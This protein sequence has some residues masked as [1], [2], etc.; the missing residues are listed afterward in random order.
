M[1][2]FLQSARVHLT[3]FHGVLAPHYKYHKFVVP[4]PAPKLE[5]VSEVQKPVPDPSL[6]MVPKEGAPTKKI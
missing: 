1:N 4:K 3:W 2:K 5:I 6:D